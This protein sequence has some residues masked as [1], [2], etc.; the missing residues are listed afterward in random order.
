MIIN[1]T[2][3]SKKNTSP[4][5]ANAASVVLPN[6]LA[7]KSGITSQAKQAADLQWSVYVARRTQ[8]PMVAVADAS[9]VA[10]PA[11]AKLEK[12][13]TKYE[14][15]FTLLSDVE[16]A[17]AEAYGVA[18]FYHDFRHAPAGRHVVKMCRAEACQSMGCDALALRAEERLGTAFGTTSPEG[19]TL[20]A[21]YCLGL[22]ACAPAAMLDGEVIGRVNQPETMDEIVQ[23]VRA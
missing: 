18:T 12:F 20:E 4:P 5:Y 15:G 1:I 22:C 8:H 19:V 23:A 21:V 14:L 9:I 3:R 11:P 6:R 2:L 17:V 13:D 10:Q 16:H 7:G